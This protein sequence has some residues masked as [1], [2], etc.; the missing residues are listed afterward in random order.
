MTERIVMLEIARMEIAHLT[1][2]IRQFADLLRDGAS[3]DDDAIARLV[4]DAYRDDEEASAEFRAVTEDD[5]LARRRD[6]VQVVLATLRVD[7][8]P[9]DVA[10]LRDDSAAEATTIALDVHQSAAWLRTLAAL[11]LVLA[12]RLGIAHEN[13]HDPDDPRFGV[14]DWLGYRLEGLLQALDD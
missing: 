7:G 2:L 9:L 3:T 13:D 14:Y 10:D 11:R 5:L 6:D 4:P 12:S 8:A 1:D